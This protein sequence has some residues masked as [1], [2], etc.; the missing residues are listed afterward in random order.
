MDPAVEV[1]G[2]LSGTE[3][4]GVGVVGIGVEAPNELSLAGVLIG[5]SDMEPP[6]TSP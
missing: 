3:A 2:V 4:G 1:L 5:T 6:V